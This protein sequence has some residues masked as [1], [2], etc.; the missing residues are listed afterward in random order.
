M[1]ASIYSIYLASVFF[2]I[3]VVRFTNGRTYSTSIGRNDEKKSN[4]FFSIFLK[5]NLIHAWIERRFY[6]P[7]P[8]HLLYEKL[9]IKE[10]G[11]LET[12][13]KRAKSQCQP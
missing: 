8:I 12:R 9:R 3:F 11:A 1:H 6:L 7:D 5:K 10:R 2:I 4:H 13:G